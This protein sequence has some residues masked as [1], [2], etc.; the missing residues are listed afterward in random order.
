MTC[1]RAKPQGKE[2]NTGPKRGKSEEEAEKEIRRF[3]SERQ[4]RPRKRKGTRS[5]LLRTGQTESSGKAFWDAR[6]AGS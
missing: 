3:C 4:T 1:E 6:S 5:A 2:G